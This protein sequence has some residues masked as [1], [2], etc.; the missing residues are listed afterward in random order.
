MKFSRRFTVPVNIVYC[1]FD[2]RFGFFLVD[3]TP[4]HITGKAWVKDETA[5][6]FLQVSIVSLIVSSFAHTW[7]IL[8]GYK[9]HLLPGRL[10]QVSG[11]SATFIAFAGSPFAHP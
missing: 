1:L 5:K 6:I 10:N 2:D 11:K 3:V 7:A 8:M 4:D 9:L